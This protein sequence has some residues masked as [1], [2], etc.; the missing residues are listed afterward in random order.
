[1]EPQILSFLIKAVND[2]LPTPVNLHAWGLTTS[3]W[4]RA[5]E[6]TASL[7]HILTGCEYALRS[8]MRWYN[9]VFEIFA[10][11]CEDM[12]WDCQ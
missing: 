6:K 10:E 8:Y 12:L 1:M 3:D 4:C 2:V 5:C 11:G 9:E 7:K